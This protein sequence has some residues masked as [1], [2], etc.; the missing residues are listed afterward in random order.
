MYNTESNG[1]VTRDENCVTFRQVPLDRQ[2]FLHG[3]TLHCL[4]LLPR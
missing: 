3:K 1:I 4:L 2:W